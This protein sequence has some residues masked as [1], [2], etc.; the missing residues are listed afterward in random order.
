MLDREDQ[1]SAEN[2]AVVVVESDAKQVFGIRIVVCEGVVDPQAHGAREVALQSGAD[3]DPLV[4]SRTIKKVEAIGILV[5]IP[6]EADVKVGDPERRQGM[7]DACRDHV[8]HSIEV[9]TIRKR[10]GEL[11]SGIDSPIASQGVASVR[12]S[13]PVRVC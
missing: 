8:T 11:V 5:V 3:F 1:L 10:F 7:F 12:H 2:V 9:G 6:N 13:D 4:F